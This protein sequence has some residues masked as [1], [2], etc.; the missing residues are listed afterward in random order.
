MN[1]GGDLA[2]DHKQT[3]FRNEKYEDKVH[4]CLGRWIQFIV[5][6]IRE[7]QNC[8]EGNEICRT[9]TCRERPRA[10]LLCVLLA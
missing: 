7:L 3:S 10:R 4:V 9:L 1:F 6:G 5:A 8:R 2:D